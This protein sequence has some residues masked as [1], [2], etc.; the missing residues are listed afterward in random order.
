ML[1][2]AWFN[3]FYFVGVR[4]NCSAKRIY[5][6]CSGNYNG[7][8]DYYGDGWDGG[9]GYGGRGR[10]RGGGRG[11]GR[12][13]GYMVQSVGYYDY[14]EYDAPPAPRGKLTYTWH[15]VSFMWKDDC[16]LNH[17]FILFSIKYFCLS[18]KKII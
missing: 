11:R 2:F 18:P 3:W 10:G 8:V 5:L 6:M 4:V 12:G 13:R 7:G 1:N 15:P 14:P 17:N 16:C 9:R